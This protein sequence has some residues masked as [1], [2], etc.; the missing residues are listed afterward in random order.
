MW[1]EKGG[2][3]GVAE[4]VAEDMAAEAAGAGEAVA[5]QRG[6]ASTSQCEGKQQNWHSVSLRLKVPGCS[7]AANNH[8]P[9]RADT[10]TH[11]SRVT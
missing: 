7:A 1:G 11:T 4:L 2:V 9:N 8:V 5:A 3:G 6:T 10:N